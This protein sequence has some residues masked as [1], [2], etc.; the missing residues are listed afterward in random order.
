MTIWGYSSDDDWGLALMMIGLMTIG[1]IGLMAIWG[2]SS[3]D[4]WSDDDWG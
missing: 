2:H 3:D 1:V 4:D